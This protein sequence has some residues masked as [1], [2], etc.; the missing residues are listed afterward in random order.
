MK[1]LSKLLNLFF[2]SK[3]TN[4]SNTNCL[5]QCVMLNNNKITNLRNLGLAKYDETMAGSCEF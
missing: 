2:N 5:S 3:Q 1:S 4:A